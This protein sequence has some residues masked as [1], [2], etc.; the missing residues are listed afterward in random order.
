MATFPQNAPEWRLSTVTRDEKNG[1]TCQQCCKKNL[2]SV[3]IFGIFTLFC[4][5]KNSLIK[6]KQYLYVCLIY[7]K[8]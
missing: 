1:P 8:P 3:K 4:Q 7:M 6:K 2:N 5:E